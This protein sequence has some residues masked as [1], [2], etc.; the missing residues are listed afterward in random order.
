MIA[1]LGHCPDC[2]A[3]ITKI[4]VKIARNGR[5]CALC[6]HR[7]KDMMMSI[8][9]PTIPAKNP[10]VERFYELIPWLVLSNLDE[11]KAAVEG[12]PS[13]D[14]VELSRRLDIVA[15]DAAYLAAYLDARA[16]PT[17]HEG[18]VAEAQRRH[19]AV[20]KALGYQ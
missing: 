14:L 10:L 6:M 9:Q 2:G 13:S 16:T 20:R 1:E 3:D 5:P 11:Y 17:T 7:I 15:A 12:I 19:K 4:E 18:A 8:K